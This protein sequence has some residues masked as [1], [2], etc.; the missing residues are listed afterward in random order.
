MLGKLPKN[1]KSFGISAMIN[2]F[3]LKVKQINL[4][5]QDKFQ[6]NQVSMRMENEINGTKEMEPRQRLDGTKYC[7]SSNL[8]VFL[9]LHS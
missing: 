3:I 6:R 2:H 9:K 7:L 5:E 8:K 4:D 1:F